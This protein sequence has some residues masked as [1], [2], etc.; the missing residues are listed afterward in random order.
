MELMKSLSNKYHIK[1]ILPI[2]HK[3]IRCFDFIVIASQKLTIVFH[4]EFQN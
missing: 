2:Q 4:A 3:T 1:T